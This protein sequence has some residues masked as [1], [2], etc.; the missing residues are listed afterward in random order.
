MLVLA[1]GER[2]GYDITRRVSEITDG[3]VT[4]GS[5]TLYRQLHQMLAN[6]WIT[7]L[8]RLESD[9]SRRRYYALLPRGHKIAMAEAQRLQR[10]VE[11][12]RSQRFLPAVT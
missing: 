8:E 4:V 12:A 7:E 10:L 11:F 2:H 9:D 3:E 6:G 1:D 5:G